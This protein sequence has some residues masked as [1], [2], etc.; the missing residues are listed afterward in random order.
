MEKVD[1]ISG[2][3]DV[4]QI[5]CEVARP[6]SCNLKGGY[7]INCPFGYVGWGRVRVVTLGLIL[8]RHGTEAA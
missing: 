8:L 2:M 7:H 1:R 3:G 4:R 6:L 5:M